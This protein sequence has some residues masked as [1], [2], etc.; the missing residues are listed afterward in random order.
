MSKI[1][2]KQPKEQILL[3][4][5]EILTADEFF[6][7]LKLFSIFFKK[8]RNSHFIVSKGYFSHTLHQHTMQWKSCHRQVL[9]PIYFLR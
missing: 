8:H 5:H 4:E 2:K 7:M 9:K 6:L 3:A 1:E